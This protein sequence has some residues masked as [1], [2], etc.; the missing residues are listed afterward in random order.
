MSLSYITHFVIWNFGF[1]FQQ[2]AEITEIR[3]ISRKF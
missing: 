2:S 3:E 1:H